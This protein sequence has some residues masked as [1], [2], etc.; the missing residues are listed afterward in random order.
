ML[1]LTVHRHKTKSGLHNHKK[2]FSKFGPQVD[3]DWWISKKNMRLILVRYLLGKQFPISNKLLRWF[4]NPTLALCWQTAYGSIMLGLHVLGRGGLLS[5]WIPSENQWNTIK[6]QN[7]EFSSFGRPSKNTFKFVAK[8]ILHFVFST[9]Y[10]QIEKYFE[11][12]FFIIFNM[13]FLDFV[14]AHARESAAAIALK[15]VITSCSITS[16]S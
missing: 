9:T 5:L 8:R 1:P 14:S 3:L 4:V 10:M 15:V 11:P 7:S 13:P 12:T 2:I 16:L 6:Y